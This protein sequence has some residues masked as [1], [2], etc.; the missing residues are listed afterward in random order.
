MRLKKMG[1]TSFETIADLLTK[2]GRGESVPTVSLP[3]GLTFPPNYRISKMGCWK[4]YR[5]RM[6]REPS[7]EA[8]EHRRLDTER[9]EELFLSLQPGIKRGDAK[10]I[11]A[12]VRVLGLKAKVVYQTPVKLEVTGKDGAPVPFA[13][14][15]AGDDVIEPEEAKMLQAAWREI[16]EAKSNKGDVG[17]KQ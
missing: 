6:D 15:L 3:E 12:A 14:S 17:G 13:V 2:A 7:L 4:A 11:D 9:L 1:V 10:A 16:Q 5:R 8:R